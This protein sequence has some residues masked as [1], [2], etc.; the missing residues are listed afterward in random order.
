[1]IRKDVIEKITAE[2]PFQPYTTDELSLLYGITS[3][4]FL[5]W[6]NPFKEAIGQKIGWYFNIRQVA[7]IFENLGRPEKEK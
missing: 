4:T 1:M 3:K 7:V 6:I 5:K 2:A